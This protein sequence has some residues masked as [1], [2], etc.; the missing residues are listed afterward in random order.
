[1]TYMDIINA[2]KG[3]GFPCSYGSFKSPPG[4][5]FTVVLFAYSADMMADNQNY[6]DISHYQ[7]EYY[8]QIKYPPDEQKIEDKLKELGIAYEKSETYIDSEDLRQI[9]YDLN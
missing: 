2:M 9:I 4:I 8:N 3:L 7:L 5:P 6:V 1:M